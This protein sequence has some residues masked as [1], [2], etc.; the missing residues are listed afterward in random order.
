MV[1]CSVWPAVYRPHGLGL[2]RALMSS[3]SFITGAAGARDRA[4]AYSG[5][6]AEVEAV[7]RL[8][9]AV[10]ARGQG[11]EVGRSRDHYT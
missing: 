5:H 11:C 4:F 7:F 1:A 6:S 10:P 8:G 9:A 3:D 2:R